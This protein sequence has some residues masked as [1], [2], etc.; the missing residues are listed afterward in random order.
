MTFYQNIRIRRSGEIL[1][2]SRALGAMQA[3]RSKKRDRKVEEVEHMLR[4]EV[5][6]YG[7]LPC[8]MNGADHDYKDDVRA[9]SVQHDVSEDDARLAF[10]TLYGLNEPLS[11]KRCG[12]SSDE[13]YEAMMLLMNGGCVA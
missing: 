13:A 12:V 2:F 7:T 8:M 3:S 1:D 10:E 9:S 4:G 11:E 6:M 5:L